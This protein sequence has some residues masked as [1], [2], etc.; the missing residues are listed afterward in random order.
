MRKNWVGKNVDLASLNDQ[1]ESFFRDKGLKTR[2]DQS[3]DSYTVLW[4]PPVDVRAG[5]TFKIITQ[6]T[7]D[8]F[9]ID[10]PDDEPARRSILSGF[11]TTLFGGGTLILRGLR[12]REFLEKTEREFWPFVE[13]SVSKLADSAGKGEG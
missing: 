6:G 4:S 2:K 3:E 11:A 1:I 12:L 13:D 7:S 10:F 8:D 9:W 5:R